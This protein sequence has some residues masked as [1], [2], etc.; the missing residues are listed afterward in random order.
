MRKTKKIGILIIFIMIYSVFCCYTVYADPNSSKGFAEYDDVKAAED[1][2]KILEEQEKEQEE[3]VGKSTNNYLE[4]LEVEGYEISPQFD[5]QTI[6]YLINEKLKSNEINI[7][8][9]PSDAKATIEGAGKIKLEENQKQCRIDV[10]AETGT[11]RTYM[12]YLG[13]QVKEEYKNELEE[14]NNLQTEEAQIVLEED[15][16]GI[17]EIDKSVCIVLVILIVAFTILFIQKNKK[18]KR[19]HG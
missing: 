11:V 1:N 15:T 8:A 2:Q 13:E 18:A 17:A 10:I 16:Q 5:K 4:S 19:K 3:M 7:I 9:T 6:E 14:S 12:I